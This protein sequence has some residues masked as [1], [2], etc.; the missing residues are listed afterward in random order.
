MSLSQNIM[1][2]AESVTLTD[3]VTADVIRVQSNSILAVYTRGGGSTVIWWDSKKNKIAATQA[4]ATVATAAGNMVQVTPQTGTTGAFHM[5]IGAIQEIVTDGSTGS[6]IK[7]FSGGVGFDSLYVTESPSA[8]QT[9]INASSLPG[10]L[11]T[12][13]FVWDSSAG[14]S[15]SSSNGVPA[16]QA[17]GT[18]GTAGKRIGTC[19]VRLYTESFNPNFGIGAVDIMALSTSLAAYNNGNVFFA[20]SVNSPVDPLN[21]DGWQVPDLN[22]DLMQTDTFDH[23]TGPIS[24]GL[25]GENS[26]GG[27]WNLTGRLEIIVEWVES[28]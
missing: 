8:L 22:S 20:Y 16:F 19:R 12:Q 10:L 24:I 11:K 6:I 17:I 27:S 25:V 2:A 21:V 5:S 23:G 26:L 3:A 18:F 7:W 14:D 1:Y 15:F 13:R 28:I 4:R 9:A